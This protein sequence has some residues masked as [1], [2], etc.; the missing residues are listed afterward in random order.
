MAVTRADLNA[1]R[2]GIHKIAKP[3]EPSIMDRLFYGKTGRMPFKQMEQSQDYWNARMTKEIPRANYKTDE[4]YAKAKAKWVKEAAQR[5]I[6]EQMQAG[7]LT[8]REATAGGMGLGI[9]AL[10]GAAFG[11]AKG[12][13]IGGLLGTIAMWAMEKYDLTPDFLDGFL[14]DASK[15][16]FEKDPNPDPSK[17]QALIAN[18][19]EVP[20]KK[21]AGAPAAP[22]QSQTGEA[23]AGTVG[24][25][26]AVG[27]VEATKPTGTQIGSKQNPRVVQARKSIERMKENQKKLDAGGGVI[28]GKAPEV[29]KT[30]SKPMV[31]A[32]GAVVT[33]G[34]TGAVAGNAVGD[35]MPKSTPGN[36]YTGHKIDG[37]WVT[38][39]YIAGLKNKRL[40]EE[41]RV[42]AE[43]KARADAA[44]KAKAEEEARVKSAAETKAKQE[45]LRKQQEMA[46]K[47]GSTGRAVRSGVESVKNYAS[48]FS[49]VPGEYAS[50]VGTAARDK[51]IQGG[52]NI[53]GALK[54]AGALADDAAGAA[55]SNVKAI[56]EGIGSWTEDKAK[57]LK[58]IFGG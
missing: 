33:A 29:A 44:A 20:A 38:D 46:E 30:M 11:G 27:T 43:E 42:A 14:G 24:T 49:D 18:A 36:T 34:T 32:S 45:A 16:V 48:A 7:W 15:G 3:G 6:D 23:G 25:A 40:T 1:A 4:E 52:E 21:A 57:K 56:G 17:M 5:A 54:E 13:A 55:V 53:T 47:V 10:L 28:A 58:Y 39:E 50:N 19:K 51:L 22:K 8:K 31:D 2:E 41:S 26:G 37:K 12:A 35:P 9:G